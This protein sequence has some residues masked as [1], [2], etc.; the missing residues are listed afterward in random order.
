[1]H[2]S[3]TTAGCHSRTLTGNGNWFRI[4]SVAKRRRTEQR[5]RRVS[6]PG[7][8]C[9]FEQCN[10][11][12]AAYMKI[13]LLDFQQAFYRPHHIAEPDPEN[14]S[15][16]SPHVF[17]SP[18]RCIYISRCK[19]Y[20]EEQLWNTNCSTT[21]WMSYLCLNSSCFL[22]DLCIVFPIILVFI[23]LNDLLHAVAR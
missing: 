9:N 14:L 12:R 3:S 15:G 18:R 4:W 10:M 22:E 2:L 21:S 16:F 7:G 20:E 8:Q 23:F 11:K 5:T 6:W 17:F 13:E 19:W 1:M